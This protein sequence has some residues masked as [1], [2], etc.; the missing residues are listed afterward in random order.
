MSIIDNIKSLASVL[1]K[2][3][4]IELYRKILDLQVEAMD[5]VEQN[6]NLKQEIRELKEKQNVQNGLVF[7]RN[8][9]WISE[10]QALKGPYCTRCWD[11]EKLLVNLKDI[12][13]GYYDCPNCRM[14]VENEDFKGR[15]IDDEEADFFKW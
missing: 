7:K 10:E 15:T 2:A 4:N 13:N 1:Q 3:D 9:Y 14:T 5:L 12:R 11:V 8:K 6:N